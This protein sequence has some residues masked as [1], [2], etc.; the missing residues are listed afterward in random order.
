MKTLPYS[1]YVKMGCDPEFFFTKGNRV[2]GSEKVLPKDGLNCVNPQNNPWGKI[3]QDGVQAEIHPLPSQ[4]R[5][6]L[7]YNLS[8]IVR[9]LSENLP[10]GVKID[11]LSQVRKVSKKELES[12]SKDSRVFGCMPTHNYYGENNAVNLVDPSIYRY[13]SCGGHIHL[14]VIEDEPA[15]QFMNHDHAQKMA[16]AI[17]NYEKL[18]PLLDV[19]VGNTCVLLDR[20]ILNKERRK[21]YGRAGEYRL[22]KHGLE[23]RTLSNFWLRSYP[24][25]SF[26]FALA[27]MAVNILAH[28]TKKDN[29]YE[30]IMSQ[31]KLSE[32]EQAINTNNFN[33]AYQNLLKV[34]PAIEDFSNPSYP[35]SKENLPFFHYFVGRGVGYWFKGDPLK[36]WAGTPNMG[37]ERFLF[38]VV[39]P[40][41]A[42]T[43]NNLKKCVE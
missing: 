40:D 38:E 34:Q 7:R 11:L 4:C 42:K 20:H 29:Y 27:R 32:I 12:L 6:S 3:V 43:Q 2:I 26:A 36:H 37:W 13:R 30:A 1:N 41:I 33:L 19:L 21:V 24:L 17:R 31:V 9:I 35:L 15:N 25:M 18:V 5:E 39:K 28:S 10:K 22:P 23:Y 8:S 14:G 16:T